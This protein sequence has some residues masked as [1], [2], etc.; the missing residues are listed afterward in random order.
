MIIV[1]VPC[2]MRPFFPG[3]FARIRYMICNLDIKFIFWLASQYL[4]WRIGTCCQSS[5]TSRV[6]TEFEV[7][8][9]HNLWLSSVLTHVIL[10]SFRVSTVDSNL[11]LCRAAGISSNMFFSHQHGRKQSC[12]LVEW[13]NFFFFF[14][15]KHM[16][17]FNN[18]HF[19]FSESTVLHFIFVVMVPTC[20]RRDQSDG[21]S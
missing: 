12:W 20:T 8:W 2:P 1:Y 17:W 19:E 13:F 11:L 3:K 14:L 21:C 9:L 18:I 6:W 7:I 5:L 16:E 10:F 4:L 15:L